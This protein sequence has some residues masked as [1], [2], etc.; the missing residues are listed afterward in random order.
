MSPAL[1]PHVLE[2]ADLSVSIA[3]PA[4]ALAAVGGVSYAVRAGETFAIVGESGCGKSM[5]SLAVMG[6]APPAARVTART[7][8]FD[9]VELLGLSRAELS[10][11]RGRHL[12]MIF[13]DPMT[14]LNPVYT[15]GDQLAEVHRR[16]LG[17]SRAA[18]R[19]RAEH[20]LERVGIRNAGA[21]LG[22]FPH[23]LSGGLRQRVMIAMALMCGP[24]LLIADEPTTA[25]DVTVQARILALLRELKRELGMSLVLITH[26][27]G[28]VA[29]L[30]DRIAVMY[31]G[32]IV[33]TGS[34]RQIF[35]AP[36]HPYT[37]GLIACLPVPGRTPPGGRLQSIP[38]MV[39]SLIGDTTG[40][41]YRNRCPH[42][43]SRCGEEDIE[44]REAAPGH[45][46][47]CALA[48]AELAAP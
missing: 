5:S 27:L 3:T 18:A 38:G 15:I 41:Q 17:S 9:G 11:I 47:R 46:Y 16:H 7:C 39:P 12:S 36:A 44:L 4:G 37:R 2:I 30:A 40:C 31:A 20:L 34:A 14:A 29:G 33:E 6:L 28:V 22:Q 1:P 23:Q 24:K 10:A 48:Q 35:K 45:E 8:R 32:R 19:E 26:D 43:Q 25:L 13:Q 21:R 42:A